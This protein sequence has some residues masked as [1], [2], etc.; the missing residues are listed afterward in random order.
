[1]PF[2]TKTVS[3]GRKIDFDAIY[4]EIIAP[5]IDAADLTP[6]RADKEAF[7]GI[8]HKAMFERLMLCDYALADLTTANANVF[9]ELGIRHGIRPRSTILISA[10]GSVVPFDVGL[11]R[12]WPYR[13]TAKGRPANPAKDRDSLA[14]A[15]RD[16]RTPQHDSPLFQLLTDYHPPDLARLKT[17]LFRQQ[18]D[19]S[20]AQRKRLAQARQDR[21]RAALERLEQSLGPVNDC[22]PGLLIDL[23]LSYRALDA[24][25]QM[26]DLVERMP[27]ELA[28][29]ILVQ[30]QLGFALN[31]LGQRD[32][33]IGVLSALITDHGPSSETNGLLG[34][35]YKDLWQ[36]AQA[37]NQPL[38]AQGFLKKAIDTYVA[39]F[40]ADWRDAYPGINAVTLMAHCTPPDPRQ[41]ELLPVVRYA[42]ER[43]LSA[44]QA[45]YWDHA[46]RLAGDQTAAEQAAADTLA[47]ATE[48]W[49]LT[50]TADTLTRLNRLPPY[51]S[52]WL[53]TIISALRQGL[54]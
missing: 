4:Q 28:G 27:P 51:Q 21:D 53:T 52:P 22:D 54:S 32:A 39:G 35:V 50:T 33:A 42:V 49:C 44:P 16:A 7:G 43:R 17:D 11:L 36:D 3:K 5:A 34:R 19:K 48:Q 45:D 26:V 30:E 6:L 38:Q 8:I 18:A 37:Q 25:Q 29:T 40:E 14:Q 2:G 9:Y 23:L 47:H 10:Q 41:H 1:M 12:H 24:H 15:L 31:R 20:E 13:L 46:S